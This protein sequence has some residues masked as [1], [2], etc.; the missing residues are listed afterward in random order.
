MLLTLMEQQVRMGLKPV[1]V[2]IGELGEQDKDIE[3]AARARGIAVLPFRMKRGYS[4]GSARRLLRMAKEEGAAILHSHGYKGNILIGTLPRWYRK[5]PM[6][7]TLHGWTATRKASKMWVYEMLDK[8]SLR[9][10]DAVIKVNAMAGPRMSEAGKSRQIREVIENGIPLLA[11]DPESVKRSDPA[12]GDFCREGFIIGVI[13][14]LSEEKGLLHLVAALQQIT[15]ERNGWKA[16]II[17]EGPHRNAVERT[18]RGASLS[19]RVLLTGYRERAWRYLPLF[20]VFV[21]PSLTE[22]LPLVI[23]EAMQAKVPIV[24]TSVGGIPEVLGHGTRGLLVPPGV[25]DALAKAVMSVQ[26]EPQK[27]DAMVEEAFVAATE[28]YTS[29]NMAEKYR[30]VY[31]EILGKDEIR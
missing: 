13:S 31:E 12:V 9:T 6:M 24:A 29:R 10:M 17:G 18:I 19:E 3:T 4:L 2:S 28:K 1:L 21:L 23:L 15:R 20:S 25:P 8:Y 27:T 14:R 30:L 7:R 22:G 5:L 16:V 11:F 26:T